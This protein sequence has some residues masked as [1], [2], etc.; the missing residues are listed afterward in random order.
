[1]LQSCHNVVLGLLLSDIGKYMQIQD[2]AWV[3][4]AAADTEEPH[5]KLLHG[6]RLHQAALPGQH[7]GSSVLWQAVH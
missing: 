3:R 1:M 2:S 7:G 5:L 4:A 6:R